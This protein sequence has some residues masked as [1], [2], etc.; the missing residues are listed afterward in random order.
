MVLLS[1]TG[2][3]EPRDGGGRHWQVIPPQ[4]LIFTCSSHYL[5]GESAIQHAS[6]SPE[7]FVKTQRAGLCPRVSD[8]ASQEQS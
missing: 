5:P 4:D 1:L 3:L 7:S 8:S 2:F 6:E